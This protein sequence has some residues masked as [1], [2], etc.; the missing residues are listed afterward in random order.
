M[1]ILEKL[2]F[3]NIQHSIT[4]NK[5]KPQK[6][7]NVEEEASIKIKIINFPNIS[8]FQII[9]NMMFPIKII[10]KSINNRKNKIE[11]YRKKY[12]FLK[13]CVELIKKNKDWIL[14]D[15]NIFMKTLMIFSKMKL[16]IILKIIKNIND[17]LIIESNFELMNLRDEKKNIKYWSNIYNKNLEN[18]KQNIKITKKYFQIENSFDFSD[19]LKFKSEFDSTID[20]FIGYVSDRKNQNI[21]C[22]Q[23]SNLLSSVN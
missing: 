15:V 16:I 2:N 7:Q 19:S 6:F 4:K 23:L 17:N 11:K 18:Y 12:S 1:S 5:H 21:Y 8:L 3:Y 10:K 20:K 9:T 22:E 13:K 14:F